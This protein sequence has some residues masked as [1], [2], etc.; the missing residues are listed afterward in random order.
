M[1]ETSHLGDDLA[2]FTGI[3]EPLAPEVRLAH[4]RH[5]ESCPECKAA[6]LEAQRVLAGIDEPALQPSPDFDARLFEKLD[7][8]D[9]AAKTESRREWWRSLLGPARWALVAGPAA[10]GLLWFVAGRPRREDESA[11]PEGAMSALSA[12]DDLELG[13]DLD[14]YRDLEAIEYLDVA[15]DLELLMNEEEAG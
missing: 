9:S 13:A 2:A 12:L 1:S 4:E 11:L 15:E 8:I 5:L 6:V 7:A 3:G 10:A 14:L